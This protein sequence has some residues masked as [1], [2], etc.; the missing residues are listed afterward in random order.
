MTPETFSSHLAEIADQTE[1]RPVLVEGNSVS[2]LGFYLTF[3]DGGISATQISEMLA[4]HNWKA[5]FFVTTDFIGTDSFLS[6]PMI[7]ELDA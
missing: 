3:D 6:P 1:C 2:E 4:P 7:R 5:H